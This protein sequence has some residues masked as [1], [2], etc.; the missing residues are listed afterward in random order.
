MTNSPIDV[1]TSCD[2]VMARQPARSRSGQIPPGAPDTAGVSK[3]GQ[4]L[5]QLLKACRPPG[6]RRG[7]TQ[8]R[9]TPASR[10]AEPSPSPSRRMRPITAIVRPVPAVPGAAPLPV[11]DTTAAERPAGQLRRSVYTHPRP[12]GPASRTSTSAPVRSTGS[13]T[14]G[15]SRQ[16]RTGAASRQCSA[17]APVHIRMTRC[18]LTSR[19]G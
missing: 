4:A 6:P 9:D 12:S 1:P 18:L 19:A 5:S 3:P 17:A 2:L 16:I 7:V 11:Y 13:G 8:F 15:S 14:V 10:R